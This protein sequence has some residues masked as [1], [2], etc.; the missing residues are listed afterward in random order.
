MRSIVALA[1][2]ALA[3]CAVTPALD[4]AMAKVSDDRPEAYKVG[5]RDGCQSSLQYRSYSYVEGDRKRDDKRFKAD[6]DYSLGWTDG[7][8]RCD[9][10]SGN[11]T[12]IKRE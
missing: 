10:G 1:V 5:Y 4:R 6:G 8:T 11:M 7:F 9:V 2:M 12:F 3:G